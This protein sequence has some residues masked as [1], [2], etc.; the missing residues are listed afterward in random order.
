MSVL[1]LGSGPIG[2]LSLLLAKSKGTNEIYVSEIKESRLN[3]AKKLGA[4]ETINPKKESLSLR[5]EAFTNGDS[6]DLVIE[7]TGA[8]NPTSEAFT[9]VKRGGTILVLGICEE[10]VEADF[11]RGVLDELKVVFSYL[12]YE[13][14]PQAIELISSNRVDVKPLVSKIIPLDTIVDEGFKDL[15]NDQSSNIKI[16]VKI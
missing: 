7:T 5:L 10:P 9:V 2:L 12:G 11:M 16:L 1:I 15:A 6:P 13:E 14:F 8:P 3:L 4:T